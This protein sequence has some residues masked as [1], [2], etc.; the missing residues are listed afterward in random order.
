MPEAANNTFTLTLRGTT[1]DGRPITPGTI[2]V[3]LLASLA[4]NFR[5]FIQNDAS[6][7]SI[8]EGSFK[9]VVFM[10]TVAL[11][12]LNADLESIGQGN[13]S[14][15]SS[16]KRMQAVKK[17]Q[18]QAKKHNVEIDFAVHEDT[19]LLI[20]SRENVLPPEKQTWFQMSTTLEGKIIE[21][22]GKDPNL[23]IEIEGKKVTVDATEEQ[24][25]EMKENLVYQIR[26]LRVSYRWNPQTDE[27]KDFVLQDIIALPKLDQEKLNI[28]IEQGTKDW[29]DVPDITAWV[30]DMRGRL[31]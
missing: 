10:T 7:A 15:V 26:R 25:R 1:P 28:L 3:G 9:I 16:P 31:E 4:E 11:N 6:E 13:Y 17:F 18:S 29:A 21:L 20:L 5:D 23:H 24:I 8:E 14:A 27:K 12:T 19:P 22:G 2:S 30:E